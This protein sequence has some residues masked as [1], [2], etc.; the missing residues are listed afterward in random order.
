[1]HN[2]TIR[3]LSLLFFA[4]I[5]AIVAA[6]QKQHTPIKLYSGYKHALS[7]FINSDKTDHKN[8]R[9]ILRLPANVQHKTNSE[10]D[11]TDSTAEEQSLSPRKK[12]LLLYLQ[13]AAE[14]LN[15]VA[16]GQSAG[17]TV[18]ST[19]EQKHHTSIKLYS[20]S[21]QVINSG[22]TGDKKAYT[23][24]RLPTNVQH[25]PNTETDD[26][27]STAEER[28]LSPREKQYQLYLKIAAQDLNTLEYTTDSQS[29]GKP[30]LGRSAM[31][32]ADSKR[33]NGGSCSIL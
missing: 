14:D 27:D 33:K 17:K 5:S 23:I 6:E 30:V 11:D 32:I 31:Q 12:D 7:R 9:T 2:A 25:K 26:T 18:C 1:M 8:N 21:H 3:I 13:M 29:A 22:K 24:L 10:T 28:S 15:I 4:F 20:D 16:D 19:A